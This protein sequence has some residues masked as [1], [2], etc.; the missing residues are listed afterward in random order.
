MQVIFIERTLHQS[1][2]FLCLLVNLP[3]IQMRYIAYDSSRD[4]VND[5]EKEKPYLEPQM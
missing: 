5:I 2:W 4:N 3:P 1:E